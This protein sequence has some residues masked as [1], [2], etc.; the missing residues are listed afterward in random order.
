MSR[1]RAIDKPLLVTVLLLALGGFIIFLSS[2]FGM[3]VY[4][5]DRYSAIIKSQSVALLLGL[6]ALY[7]ASHIPPAWYKAAALPLFGAAAFINL[8]VFIP[9]IGYAANGAQRWISLG[10]TSFQPSELLKVTA[11]LALAYLLSKYRHGPQ[12]LKES[13]LPFGIIAGISGILML[14]Q[15]DTD[16]F[17]VIV[18][19]GLA[20]LFLAGVKFR[21]IAMILGIGAVL[22]TILIFQRPYIQ[23]RI[24]TYLHPSSDPLGQGYHI[25][26]SLIAIGSGEWTGRGVGRGVQKYGYLPEPVNDAIFAVY[27]EEFGFIGAFILVIAFVL[28]LWRSLRLAK[29]S[30]DSFA[31]LTIAGI[32]IV[33]VGESFMNISSMLGIIPLSGM[34][35]VFVSQG[36]TSLMVFLAALGICLSLSRSRI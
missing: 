17:I 28:L 24:N 7:I 20:L 9:G 4:D 34:P 8:L 19:S 2:A 21:Y 6:L 11:V 33:I 23:E 10:F 5:S 27:A 30:P 18:G 13:L 31:Q 29:N 14:L 36:G 16:T 12:T 1:L 25:Q 15:K 26:Q 32:G 3:L 35:L 22:V